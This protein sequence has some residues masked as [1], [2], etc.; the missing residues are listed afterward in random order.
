M[1]EGG[2]RKHCPQR[3]R[4]EDQNK[5]VQS[6]RPACRPQE[7]DLRQKPDSDI[8]GLFPLL[9]LLEP[10]HQLWDKASTGQDFSPSLRGRTVGTNPGG[11]PEPGGGLALGRV[12]PGA[13][14]LP[15]ISTPGQMGGVF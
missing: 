12:R 9:N 3:V 8:P 5:Q 1:G 11:L 7:T 13:R 4:L 14:L 15:G 6:H 2:R 10:A